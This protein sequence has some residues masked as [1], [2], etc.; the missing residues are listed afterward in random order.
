[1]VLPSWANVRMLGFYTLVRNEKLLP[2]EM[3]TV[4]A[5][6][7]ERLVSFADLYLLHVKENSLLLIKTG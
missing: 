4:T 2:P 5:H 6:I 7:K 1:M 3:T